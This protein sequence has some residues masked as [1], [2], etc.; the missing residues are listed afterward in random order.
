V[1]T[2]DEDKSLHRYHPRKLS[3]WSLN[4]STPALLRMGR[5]CGAAGYHLCRQASTRKMVS[6]YSARMSP[7]TANYLVRH[8]QAHVTTSVARHCK[9]SIPTPTYASLNGETS[10]HNPSAWA[11]V[12]TVKIIAKTQTHKNHQH[13]HTTYPRPYLTSHIA[14]SQAM[15][16]RQPLKRRTATNPIT[17]EDHARPQTPQMA[18]TPNASIH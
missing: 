5:V 3:T 1:R 6:I 7:S 17:K 15:S 4:E 9:G 13:M 18:T 11:S 8:L 16:A 10:H 2:I 14:N 12:H